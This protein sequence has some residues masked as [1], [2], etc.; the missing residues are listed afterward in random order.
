M[1]CKVWIHTR[2]TVRCAGPSTEGRTISARQPDLLPD[3]RPVVDA[4]AGAI[5]RIYNHYIANTTATFEEEVLTAG[6]LAARMATVCDYGLPWLVAE[7]DG[8]LLG[9][10]Y[11]TRW[12]SRAAYRFSVEVSVYVDH[13][14]VARGIGS[15]LYRQLFAELRQRNVNAVIGGITLPNPAS[16][17][18][19]ERCGMHKVA[20]FSRVGYK[21]GRWLD[22]G[23]WQLNLSRA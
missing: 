11:A 7:R 5:A 19:H 12:R 10:A 2:G 13:D 18:F 17:A 14:V 6:D 22:V 23:Y 21:F 20:H 9:Y 8:G 4:D 16:V 15:A 1:R 3:V